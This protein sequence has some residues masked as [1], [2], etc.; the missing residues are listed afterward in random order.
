MGMSTMRE[1]GF[2]KVKIGMTTLQEVI[3]VAGKEE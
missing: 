1:D 2:R 3:E